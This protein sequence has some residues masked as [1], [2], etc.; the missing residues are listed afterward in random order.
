MTSPIQSTNTPS[1]LGR[2]ITLKIQLKESLSKIEKK[3]AQVQVQ[4]ELAAQI[5]DWYKD[6][7]KELQT[8]RDLNPIITTHSEKLVQILDSYALLQQPFHKIDARHH[9][10]ESLIYF[11]K[12]YECVSIPQQLEAV[13]QKIQEIHMTPQLTEEQDQAIQAIQ[14]RHVQAEQRRQAARIRPARL[15]PNIQTLQSIKERVEKE[16]LENMKK[17]DEL[18][19]LLTPDNMASV[20]ESLKEVE[21]RNKQISIRAEEQITAVLRLEKLYNPF[22]DDAASK[23]QTIQLPKDLVD[24]ALR[25]KLRA[26]LLAFKEMLRKNKMGDLLEETLWAWGGKVWAKF[27]KNGHDE[28][29]FQ[30]LL[31]ELSQSL[32][33]VFNK[34]NRDLSAHP[35]LQDLERWLRN[36]NAKSV[37]DTLENYRIKMDMGVID[38]LKALHAERE[39][40]KKNTIAA[41]R[42][43]VQSRID[44]RMPDILA[45][46]VHTRKLNNDVAEVVGA[47][48]QKMAEEDEQ[49]ANGQLIAM[50]V[51]EEERLEL[52]R[53]NVAIA[54]RLDSSEQHVT[55]LA[56]EN[57]NVQVATNQVKKA[58][59]KQKKAGFKTLLK[60]AAIV[61][62][63]ALA[64]WGLGVTV[65]PNASGASVIVPI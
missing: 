30:E 10:V 38:R 40:E 51:L 29:M 63:C 60:T 17:I 35:A 14:A 6:F 20:I 52:D 7:Q 24:T 45:P 23:E 28:P 15:S 36:Y 33:M 13:Y 50:K 25:R 61:T 49:S 53:R 27:L 44:A 47:E 58:L 46:I 1:A 64:T 65:A 59:K 2:G 54:R 16:T 42:R 41:K 12:A 21:A 55:E 62:A 39:N 18:D 5:S 37:L 48:L 4:D 57:M 19:S 34:E 31:L 9:L 22:S 56:K 26:D 3:L 32:T 43:E 8:N 11:L